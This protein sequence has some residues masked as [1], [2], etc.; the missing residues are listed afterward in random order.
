MK[1]QEARMRKIDPTWIE[2]SNDVVE[3]A[4]HLPRKVPNSKPIK[5]G[6]AKIEKETVEPSRKSTPRTAK[7]V[8]Q[9][10]IND[11]YTDQEETVLIPFEPC[12]KL[13]SIEELDDMTF[14]EGVF[15]D[16]E[17]LPNELVDGSDIWV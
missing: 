11:F 1:R 15:D 9:Q 10:K 13:N 5:A 6:R 16:N 14:L 7:T 3:C 4:P 8:A 2:I 17:Y 12:E